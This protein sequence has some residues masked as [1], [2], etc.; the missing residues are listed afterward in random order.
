MKC[1]MI[2]VC[3]IMSE[4]LSFLKDLPLLAMRI[5]LAI[6]F[7]TPGMKKF[8]DINAIGEWF[9]SMDYPLPMFNAYM[10]AGTEVVGAVLLFFGFASRLISIPLMVI[11]FVAIFT[12]HFANG[13][14]A[15]NNGYEIPLYYLIMLFTIT[16]YG[17][18]KIS[19]EGIIKK[20]VS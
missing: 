15:S 16:I 1:K 12:V 5:I 4:K 19:L 6:G 11:M 3:D 14:E 2:G 7:W 13:F 9:K 20:I 18:G 8:E 17:G 10:A